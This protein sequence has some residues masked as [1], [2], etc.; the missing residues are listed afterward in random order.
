MFPTPSV[1]Y[2]HVPSN[3][4]GSS[5]EHLCHLL[6]SRDRTQ[7]LFSGGTT[8]RWKWPPSRNFQMLPRNRIHAPA[9]SSP[10]S[11][12]GSSCLF[13]RQGKLSLRAEPSFE[14]WN[15]NVGMAPIP[16]VPWTLTVTTD[17][18]QRGW[19][20]KTGTLKGPEHQGFVFLMLTSAL[21]ISVKDIKL[22]GTPSSFPSGSSGH[23]YDM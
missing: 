14:T 5:L 12:T 9:W 15:A 6:P 7:D 22:E 4:P 10:L 2:F 23:P 20:R 1:M 19:R 21:L 8:I 11:S 13:Y 3:L 17:L 16:S 18:Q